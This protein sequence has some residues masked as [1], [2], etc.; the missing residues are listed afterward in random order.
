M[1]QSLHPK[2][3]ISKAKTKF[4]RYVGP[5]TQS[6]EQE[7]LDEVELVVVNHPE[8][9]QT[10]DAEDKQTADNFCEWCEEGFEQQEDLESHLPCDQETRKVRGVDVEEREQKIRRYAK[11][12][13][14]FTARQVGED[15]FDIDPESL[16]KGTLKREEEAIRYTL[17]R[18]EGLES[19]PSGENSQKIYKSANDQRT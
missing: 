3:V 2:R 9:N 13:N 14:S 6:T 11:A 10:T 16:P 5:Q 19:T 4:N 1:S 15:V 7:P 12:R 17:K 8:Y 18:I